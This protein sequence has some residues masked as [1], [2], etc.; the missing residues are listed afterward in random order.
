MTTSEMANDIC[1][2]IENCSKSTIVDMYNYIFMIDYE[3]ED[4]KDE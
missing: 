3:V 4:V 1:E 2:F